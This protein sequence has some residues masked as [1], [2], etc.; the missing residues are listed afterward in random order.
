MPTQ[1]ERILVR[2][3]REL[4]QVTAEKDAESTE[5]QEQVH[6]VSDSSLSIIVQP[7]A[8]SEVS[9]VHVWLLLWGHNL[10][11]GSHKECRPK[12]C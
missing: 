6:D 2:A 10:S 3:Q 11:G 5:L 8:I 4:V 9:N 7:I 12:T 1:L